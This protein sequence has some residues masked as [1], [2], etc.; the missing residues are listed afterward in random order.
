[1]PVHA[2]CVAATAQYCATGCPFCSSR[3][4]CSL[5]LP[6]QLPACRSKKVAFIGVKVYAVALYVEAEKMARE[7]GVRNRCC[8]GCCSCC[9]CCC[10]GGGGLCV[11]GGCAA[12]GRQRRRSTIRLPAVRACALIHILLLSPADKPAVCILRCTRHASMAAA[13]PASSKA[14]TTTSASPLLTCLLCPLLRTLRCACR[15]VQGRL[16]RGRRR[17]LPGP[18][19][20]RLR[21][22]AAAAAGAGC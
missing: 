21:Q 22:G 10:G 4:S 12:V 13:G 16:L 1:M 19:R 17:L 18:D 9:C 15:A 11:C 8:C 3:S 6:S 14:A 20:R 2:C 5:H 7:L